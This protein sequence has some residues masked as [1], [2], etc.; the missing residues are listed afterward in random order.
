METNTPAPEVAQ[1]KTLTSLAAEA[2]IEAA[3]A[4]EELLAVEREIEPMIQKQKAALRRWSEAYDR[5]N[6]L[7]LAVKE[8]ENKCSN[9]RI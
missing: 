7:A 5:A 3:K 9:S 4:R 1:P 2:Q 6:G 8:M